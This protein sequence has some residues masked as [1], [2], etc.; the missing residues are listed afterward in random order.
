MT[1]TRSSFTEGLGRTGNE[2]SSLGILYITLSEMSLAHATQH[3]GRLPRP[4][5]YQPLRRHLGGGAEIRTL[6][7]ASPGCHRIRGSSP[8]L[9]CGP[10]RRL[11]LHSV[12]PRAV[13]TT[14]PHACGAGLGGVGPM[15]RGVFQPWFRSATTTPD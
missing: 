14:I 13:R 5:P 10:S 6:P 11:T 4:R 8:S 2:P 7:T 9:S 15:E 12:G 1:K 3:R